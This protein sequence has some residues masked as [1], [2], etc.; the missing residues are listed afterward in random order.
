MNRQQRR[1]LG[2]KNN[3]AVLTL[4]RSDAKSVVDNIVQD[5]L[6]D[7]QAENLDIFLHIM[8]M[9]CEAEFGFKKARLL[10][11]IDRI[12]KQFEAVVSGEVSKLDIKEYCRNELKVDIDIRR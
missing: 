8:C 2:K 7:I 1:Q 6:R 9:A 4:K 10:K 3:E 12:S 11:L 5:R